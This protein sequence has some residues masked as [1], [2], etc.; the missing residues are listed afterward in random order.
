MTEDTAI[1]RDDSI[2]SLLILIIFLGILGIIVIMVLYFSGFFG[3]EEKG[4]DYEFL[5]YLPDKNLKSVVYIQANEDLFRELSSL[6][7][8]MLGGKY[9][10]DIKNSKIAVASY[11]DGSSAYLLYLDTGQSID[12]MIQSIRDLSNEYSFSGTDIDIEK[13][14]VDGKLFY[15]ITGDRYSMYSMPLCAWEQGNGVIV[16]A[17]Q[18]SYSWRSNIEKKDCT[19]IISKRYNAKKFEVFFA[20]AD[21]LGKKIKSNRKVY[22]EGWMRSMEI[23]GDK[24]M[25]GFIYADGEGDY[26]L[27]AG[28]Q[29]LGYDTSSNFCIGGRVIKRADK[30]ACSKEQSSSGIPLIPLT[31]LIMLERG[32]GDYSIHVI[33]YPK[34]ISKKNVKRKAEDLIFSVEL[35]G[36]EKMWKDK[37]SLT[38]EVKDY[39]TKNA[40]YNAKVEV[41]KGYGYRNRGDLLREGYT[42]DSGLVRFDDM[43]LDSVRLLITKEGYDNDTEYVSK[44]ETEEIIYLK[45]PYCG[46][47]KCSGIE[48]CLN[49]PEDCKCRRGYICDDGE[50]KKKSAVCGNS[51]CE[52]GEN[53]LTCPEDCKCRY[54]YVCVDGVCKKEAYSIDL[55]DV[56]GMTWNIT[57]TPSSDKIKISSDRCFYLDIFDSSGE[58]IDP[59]DA[60]V[61]TCRNSVGKIYNTTGP[62]SASWFNWGGCASTKYYEVERGTDLILRVH[63]DSCPSCVCY[64]PDFNIYEEIDGEWVK[65]KN[66]SNL[67]NM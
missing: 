52:T 27:V 21:A 8:E 61:E 47:G 1:K 62:N 63:T 34:R 22:A 4:I 42:N 35:E 23:R 54:N 32:I 14:T 37:K 50:C 60:D 5:S 58:E 13:K 18:D 11:K 24:S 67:R 3:W 33:A 16:L 53:C 59:Y 9:I 66:G 38:V 10:K 12:E 48:N 20:E 29:I 6:I 36:E 55:P 31:S 26:L 51:M 64:H 15:I 19:S 56:K 57:Y 43:P 17:F 40:I 65:Y 44:T 39:K 25:Y 28:D 45:K 41:Y 46:D 2:K 30:E 7:G 49:C